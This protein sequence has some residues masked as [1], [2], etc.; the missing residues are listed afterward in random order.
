MSG[1]RLPRM[2]NFLGVSFLSHSMLH[3]FFPINIYW[4]RIKQ[5][6]F[7]LIPPP[8]IS[9]SLPGFN[10]L[11]LFPHGFLA[12]LGLCFCLPSLYAL[13]WRPRWH[14]LY[15]LLSTLFHFW[16]CRW[17]LGL[18]LVVALLDLDTIRFFTV[19]Y[20]DTFLTIF[21]FKFIWPSNTVSDTYSC[22]SVS[23]FQIRPF[24]PLFIRFPICIAFSYYLLL[25]FEIALLYHVYDNNVAVFTMYLHFITWNLWI[26]W[27]PNSLR[28]I[29]T[30]EYAI[31][32]MYVISQA[33]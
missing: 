17:W 8:R 16:F 27:R 25:A 20:H 24:C 23:Y 12:G 19:A 6:L 13:W 1:I 29:Q 33:E 30:S 15:Y 31:A 28:R 5:A 26:L 10:L 18:F 9:E 11:H 7:I 2:P 3:I 32:A 14:P 4:I 21:G 22:I